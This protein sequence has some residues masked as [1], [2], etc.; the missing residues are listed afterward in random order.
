MRE[1]LART[2]FFFLTG[3]F[4]LGILM[5]HSLDFSFRYFA[6]IFAIFLLT[7]VLFRQNKNAPILFLLIFFCAGSLT[8]KFWHSNH[9]EHPLG[10]QLPLKNITA[11]GRVLS[12]PGAGKRHFLFDLEE[13]RFRG[14]TM[15]VHLQVLVRARNPLPVFN[16]GDH[17]VLKQV[18]LQQIP[19]ARN[20]GQFDYRDYLSKRGIFAQVL[21]SRY[22]GVK[23]V[24]GKIKF[25]LGQFF[26][27]TRKNLNTHIHEILPETSAGFLAA[28]LLG[29]RQEI[30]P[31]I[32][33]DFQNTGVAHVL[34]ISGLH[35]GFVVLIIYLMISFLPLSFRWHNLLTILFLVMYMFLTGA[36]PPVVRATLM[37]SLYLIGENMERKPNAYNIVWL[38][39][40]LI[41]LVQPQQLFWVSFQFSFIA[42]LSIFYFY[43][44]LKPAE[45]KICGLLPETRWGFFL[46]KW[47]V[48]AFLISLAAQLGTLPL[49]AIYFHKIPLVSFFLNLLVIPLIGFIVGVGFLTLF[50]SY[51][52]IRF[53]APV[54]ALLSQSIQ[55]M[56]EVVHRAANLPLAYL[57]VSGVSV[58]VIIFYFLVLFLVFHWA[59][60]TY[61]AVRKPLSALAVLLLIWLV[62]PS[63]RHSQFIMMDVG[64]GDACLLQTAGEKI[65][66]FDAGPS[67]VTWDSGRD[68]VL[69]VLQYLGNRRI[70]K[71]IIT[72][73]HAD[74]LGGMYSLLESVPIDSVYLPNL[75]VPVKLQN[76]L[77]SIL[78]RKQVPFRRVQ[79]GE[80]L[81]VD[82]QTR[83]Y[84]LSPFPE[85]EKPDDES[86]SQINNCSVVSLVKIGDAAVL[87][88]GDAERPVEVRLSAW[89]S[90]MRADVLKVAHH[91]STT[92]STI[93]FL[94]Q[95]TPH[96]GLISVGKYNRYGHPSPVVLKRLRS[97][98]ISTFRTDRQGAIW[99][100][101]NGGKWRRK[102]WR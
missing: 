11:S 71:A 7:L 85:F 48:K 3:S 18:V 91:G 23:V 81:I 45:E 25:S 41:L 78:S 14:K 21:L 90:L 89:G 59:D 94:K 70:D 42:V 46:R 40:F 10:K 13:I 60:E 62:L 44:L 31:E 29:E 32:R 57:P 87:I 30:D 96:F 72:H 5:E 77:V 65:I 9:L 88:T 56:I 26:H 83:I 79:A 52:S 49:M 27:R 20:P 4:A 101:E 39:A 55:V 51:L 69:P 92:S 28:V 75:A 68:V 73:P 6:A 19:G 64:Q 36:K 67:Y 43:R 34:A 35:V 33:S 84:F 47:I 22:S 66:L 100:G 99:L 50:L 16:L 58:V 12:E 102:D 54:A 93:G 63:L 82:E 80:R 86:D 8:Y 15:P 76:R 37:I 74:H 38:A 98:G 61:R 2:P 53:A 17:L 24:R 95:V 1:N 97:L